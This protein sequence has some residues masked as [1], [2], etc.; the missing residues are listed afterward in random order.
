MKTGSDKFMDK[1]EF[2]KLTTK[3]YE[4]YGFVKKGKLYYLDL[5][6]VLICSGFNTINTVLFLAFTFR[7][8]AIHQNE[9]IILNDMF[10]G[11]DSIQTKICL[12]RN[13][14]GYR[15]H[16]ICSGKYTEEE[17]RAKLTPALHYYFDPF[18]IDAFTH[19]KRAFLEIGYVEEGNIIMLKPNA[20]NFLGVRRD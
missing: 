1:K 16:E 12:D 15:S 4:E 20:R 11:F 17:W 7:I 8:K 13:V 5:P 14:K 9:G 10:E 6:D 18:K 3:V 19:I 2:K